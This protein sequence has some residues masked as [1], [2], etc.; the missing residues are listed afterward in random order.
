MAAL[1]MFACVIS[2]GAA[3]SGQYSLQLCLRVQGGDC[4]LNL[5]WYIAFQ[6]GPTAQYHQHII[7]TDPDIIYL[8]IDEKDMMIS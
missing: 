3:T 7:N 2:K 5:Q 6:Q 8:S 4:Q 1:D